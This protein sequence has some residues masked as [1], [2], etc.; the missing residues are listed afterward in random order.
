MLLGGALAGVVLTLPAVSAAFKGL[1]N[2]SRRTDAGG[3]PM[4]AGDELHVGWLY[5][6]A[7]LAVVTLFVITV[8]GLFPTVGPTEAFGRGIVVAALG[9]LW[10]WF[11]SVIIAQATGMTDWT[12][13]SGMALLSVVVLMRLSGRRCRAGD[14]ARRRC[15]CR[16]FAQ[17]GHAARSTHRA[18][19]R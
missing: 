16:V 2:A 9:S 6:S 17:R 15:E 10:V 18:T 11:A 3:E 8:T 4:T 12:P 7:T 14:L 5:A 13:L 19:R 1:V